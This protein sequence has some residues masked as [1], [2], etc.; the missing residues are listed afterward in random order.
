MTRECLPEEA[1]DDA[2]PWEIAQRI[3]IKKEIPMLTNRNSPKFPIISFTNVPFFG[4]LAAK[5]SGLFF[6]IGLQIPKA[7]SG[8]QSAIPSCQ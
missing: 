1:E 8:A 2:P 4:G 6:S 5:K 3:K 7:A